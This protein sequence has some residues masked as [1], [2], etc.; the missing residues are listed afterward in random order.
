MSTWRE[1]W[2][3]EKCQ[4]AKRLS[5]G[6]AG[7]GYAEAAI[8]VCAT[9]NSLALDLWPGTGIDRVRFIE[10]L[11]KISPDAK[12]CSTISIPLLIQHLSQANKSSDADILTKHFSYTKSSFVITGPEIDC[13]ESIINGL[14]PNLKPE[15]IRQFSY[16][17][18]LYGE[19]RSAY[20]HEYQPGDNAGTRPMSSKDNQ[21]VS[22]IN[23]LCDDLQIRR[24]MHFHIE[25][26][27]QLPVGIATAVDKI[28]SN[29]NPKQPSTWWGQR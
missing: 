20:A 11:V 6:E 3:N 22:Y 23:R 12:I 26:L 13:D 16:A 28:L 27:L 19:I 10:L 7:G 17:S 4:L 1:N 18:I 2:V 5:Q 25:W 14:L 8:I 15:I 29:S 9:L 21:K 24:Q